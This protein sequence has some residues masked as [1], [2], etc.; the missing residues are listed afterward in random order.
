MP[1]IRAPRSLV[2]GLALIGLAAF[3]LWA[4][5]DLSQGTMRAM[6]PAMLPRVVAIAI[7]I[8][9]LIFVAL[10]FLQRGEPLPAW[11]LRGPLIVGAGIAVFALTI[12]T[13]GFAV[14]APLAMLIIGRG[15]TE[16]RSKELAVFAAVMT[17]FC[18]GLFR[19]LLDQPIPVLIIPG[20]DIEF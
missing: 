13:L 9:G 20:T 12:R 11:E 18:L 10:G 16:V 3:A 2:S 1:S 8:C 5:G 15:T 4:V 7:G 17:I 6:G 14:A 19:Y